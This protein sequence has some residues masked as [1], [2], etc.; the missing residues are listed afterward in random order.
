MTKIPG[1]VEHGQTPLFYD[2]KF[3][4]P[5]CDKEIFVPQMGGAPTHYPR[6]CQHCQQDI[7][8]TSPST[9]H[10]K[11]LKKE[12][13]RLANEPVYCKM[14]PEQKVCDL[15]KRMAYQTVLSLMQ[16]LEEK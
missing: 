14:S 16:M 8:W 9:T 3:I 10:W 11:L 1:I 6:Q 15:V 4:C 13:E 12:V 5:H 7:E 2:H